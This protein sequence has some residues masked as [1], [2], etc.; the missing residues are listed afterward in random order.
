MKQPEI[1]KEYHGKTALRLMKYVVSTYRIQF[2]IV[3]IAIMISAIAN[4]AGPLFLLYLIDDFITPLIGKQDP[5]FG[6][7]IQMVFSFGALYYLGV[8][9]TYLYNRL[10]VNIGQGVLKR[11]RDDMFTHMQTLPIGFSIPIPTARS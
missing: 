11:V 4:M 3:V 2:V 5:D 10:M 8:L 9:C 1:L 7:L 6:N